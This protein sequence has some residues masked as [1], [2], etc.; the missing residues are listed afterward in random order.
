MDTATQR[1]APD[2]ASAVSLDALLLAPFE[3][4]RKP[5]DLGELLLV[6][7]VALLGLALLAIAADL[8][9]GIAYAA[10]ALVV[11]NPLAVSAASYALSHRS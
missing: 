8:A 4:A 3:Q 6:A 9:R 10:L 7:A 11:A 2:P 5:S 1:P